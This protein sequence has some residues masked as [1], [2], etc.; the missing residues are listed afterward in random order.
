M[1]R[2]TEDIAVWKQWLHKVF[3]IDALPVITI[4]PP[5]DPAAASD[6]PAQQM[7]SH[8]MSWLTLG[9]AIP[10]ILFAVGVLIFM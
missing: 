9:I 7:I 4:V 5:P 10:S 6:R 3:Q 1:A 2:H 8:F